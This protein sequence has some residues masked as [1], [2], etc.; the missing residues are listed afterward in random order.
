MFQQH[1]VSKILWACFKW[2][3]QEYQ[4]LTSGSLQC[5]IRLHLALQNIVLWPAQLQPKCECSNERNALGLWICNSG[6]IIIIM[7][8]KFLEKFKWLWDIM[9]RHEETGRLQPPRCIL[10]TK[11]LP[12]KMTL[13]PKKFTSRVGSFSTVKHYIPENIVFHIITRSNDIKKNNSSESMKLPLSL[14]AN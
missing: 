2:F 7:F 8:K 6:N 12:W 14:S 10:L 1:S 9:K 4:W 5:N 13:L 11:T 3:G